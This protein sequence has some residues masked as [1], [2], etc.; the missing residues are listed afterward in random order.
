MPEKI[1]SRKQNTFE[2]FYKQKPDLSDLRIFG[3]ISYAHVLPEDHKHLEPKAQRGIFVGF[4]ERRRGVRIILDGQR[5]YTVHR[6]AVYYEHSLLSAMKMKSDQQSSESTNIQ[7][8]TLEPRLREVSHNRILSTEPSQLNKHSELEILRDVAQEKRQKRT[9]EMSRKEMLITPNTKPVQ[10]QLTPAANPDRKLT[11]KYSRLRRELSLAMRAS[12]SQTVCSVTVVD[13]T[14]PQ[15]ESDSGFDID[16][17]SNSFDHVV[18]AHT[19]GGDGSEALGI[20]KTITQ[21]MSSEDSE[22]WKAAILDELSNH[23][24][25]FQS[26]GPPIPKEPGIKATPTRFFV[27]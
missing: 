21:A 15:E 18:A 10:M 12:Y 1:K 22:F 19:A 4:D 25:V 5:K 24:E 11:G 9:A 16:S 27:F 2:A 8:T 3:C 6:T 14:D 26:Y 20:P 13:S 17:P 23:E 7:T